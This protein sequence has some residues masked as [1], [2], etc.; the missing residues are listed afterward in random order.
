MSPPIP[1]G[2]TPDRALLHRFLG[3]PLDAAIASGDDNFHLLRLFA[4]SLVVYG[5]SWATALNPN[6]DTD[7]LGQR[8]G[9]F[10]GTVAVDMFFWISG[11]LV[12]MSY[13]RRQSAKDF[14]LARVLRIFPA[15][16]VCV[17]AS[18]LLLGPLVTTLSAAEYFAAPATWDYLSHNIRLNDIQWT[19]PG[20]F[21][22]NSRA[23]I[24]NGCLW[25][26]PGEIRMYEYV[27]ILG[28]LGLLRSATGFWCGLVLLACLVAGWP[29]TIWLQLDDYREFAAFFVGGAACWFHR[30]RIPVSTAVLLVLLVTAAVLHDSTAYPLLLRL[31]IGYATLWLAYGAR[32]PKVDRIGDY[33]Y[34]IYL[35]GFPMQQLV[36]LWFPAWGP[37]TSL[38]LSLPLSLACAVVSWHA[39]EKPAQD[40]R[41]RFRPAGRAAGVATA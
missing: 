16:I 39:V 12:T 1:P 20:V 7:P 22:G 34:G 30:G 27:L 32:L 40:L 13:A 10:S 29:E 18:T 4:A 23:G 25:T 14:L 11:F 33:S 41:R 36:A 19:L 5:H 9:L 6:H 26:L 21:T 38:L 37:W 24:V 8:I 3:R 17:L 15:L 28:V 35:Y 31:C 2:A